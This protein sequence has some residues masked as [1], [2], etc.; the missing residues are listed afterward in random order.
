MEMCIGN[1]EIISFND[2]DGKCRWASIA[3]EHGTM[4]YYVDTESW[5]KTLWWVFRNRGKF[6]FKRVNCGALIH[7]S[8]GRCRV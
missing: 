5:V 6:Q 7:D 3:D 2:K 1:L 4:K 8:E